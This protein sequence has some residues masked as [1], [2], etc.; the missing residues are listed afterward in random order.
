MAEAKG[1]QD[2]RDELLAQLGLQ[3][4]D[5]NR[6]PECDEGPESEPYNWG[7]VVPGVASSLSAFAE[8]VAK[9]FGVPVERVVPHQRI[10]PVAHFTVGKN[11]G[12]TQLAD[13]LQKLTESVNRNIAGIEAFH[14]KLECEAPKP[15]PRNGPVRNPH[16]RHGRG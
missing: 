14:D 3:F 7:G 6:W 9:A 1:F 10:Q 2:S 15:A 12:V 16:R 13:N 11:G 8:T 4:H 5:L